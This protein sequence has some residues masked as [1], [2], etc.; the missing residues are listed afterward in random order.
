MLP[1][2]LLYEFGL[3]LHWNCSLAHRQPEQ[4]VCVLLVG[5]EL[6]VNGAMSEG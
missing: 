6:V 1:Y 5:P 4:N 3:G 2:K